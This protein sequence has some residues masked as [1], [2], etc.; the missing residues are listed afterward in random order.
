MVIATEV[1]MG[2]ERDGQNF[3]LAHLLL[4][5]A[6]HSHCF[7][8]I[9]NDAEGGKIS[10]SFKIWL[11]LVIFDTFDVGIWSCFWGLILSKKQGSDYPRLHVPIIFSSRMAHLLMRWKFFGS[12]GALPSRKT[13]RHSLFTIRCRFGLSYC[14]ADM[15]C[16]KP[17]QINSVAHLLIVH[18]WLK[19]MGW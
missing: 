18:A 2:D 8:D 16:P 13:I 4:L 11:N 10:S 3:A 19:A 15:I 1:A 9:I 5:I 14:L 6:L 7:Y 17:I 12:A